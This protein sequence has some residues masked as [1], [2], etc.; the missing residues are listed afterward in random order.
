MPALSITF[1]FSGLSIDLLL[2]PIFV[3][4]LEA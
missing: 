4:S 2:G 3:H 1:F